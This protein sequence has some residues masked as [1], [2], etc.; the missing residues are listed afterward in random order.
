MKSF[1]VVI[2]LF[3][4]KFLKQD[5]YA[6]LPVLELGILIRLALNSDP[7]FSASQ[8]LGWIK[9]MLHTLRYFIF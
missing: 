9:D 1:V 6:I 7:F 5:L 3:W 8:L 4:I 2:V